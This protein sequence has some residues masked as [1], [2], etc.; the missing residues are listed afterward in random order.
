MKDAAAL[1]VFDKP[2]RDYAREIAQRRIGYG[3]GA[4]NL[5]EV[6]AFGG[7][8]IIAGQ[9]GALAVAAYTVVLNVVS[10]IFMV[11]LGLATATAVLVARAYG[12]GDQAGVTRAALV[13]FSVAAAFGLAVS[14]IVWP[15]AGLIARGVHPRPGGHRGGHVGP[16][17]VGHLPG[18]RRSAGGG[19]PGPAH[20]RRRA[21]R[22][23]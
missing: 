4:S 2:S 12:A 16:G 7:M 8:N 23:R 21:G 17:P 14:L 15:G 18:P 6:A 10:L 9:I 3:A 5:F 19:R 11:P 20:P 13:G 22:R 1:G